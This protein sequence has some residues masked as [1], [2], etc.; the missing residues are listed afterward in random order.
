[1]SG[2]DILPYALFAAVVVASIVAIVLAGTQA[3]VVPAIALP[4]ALAYVLYD[5]RLKL[6]ERDRG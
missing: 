5:R 6:R 2:I 3:W 4:F 1:M